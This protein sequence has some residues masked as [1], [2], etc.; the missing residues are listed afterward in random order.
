MSVP[1]RG[2]KIPKVHSSIAS[3]RLQD[4]GYDVKARP[5]REKPLRTR[6]HELERVRIC[7]D[8]VKKPR[9]YFTKGLHLVMDNKHWDIPL[10]AR[11][12]RYSKMRRIRFHLHTRSEGLKKNFT[13]PSKKSKHRVSVGG[14]VNVCA[15]I[16]NNKVVLWHYLPKRWSGE[17]AVELY[18]GAV[19]TALKKAHG[20]L[21]SYR[22]L[23]DNDPTGYKSNKAVQ[24]KQALRISPIEYPPYSPDLNPLDFFLWNEVERRMNQRVIA[25]ETM[26][27]YKA[28][29]SR[30]AKSIPADV[31]EKAL[32]DIRV[33]A[34]QVID[35][36]GGD[37]QKD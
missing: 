17:A 18:K 9:T 33:R 28:R 32:A 35:A 13:R 30:T 25:G 19:H 7:K 20:N 34:Q 21:R 1:L 2:A 10:T 15:G 12:K 3:R 24:I 16:A 8:L 6:D 5:P 23:E 31:I 22:I 4:A 11:S 27:R 36:D 14:S 37:I 29:L 26:T